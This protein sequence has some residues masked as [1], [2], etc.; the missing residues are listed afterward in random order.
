MSVYNGRRLRLEV[1]GASHVETIGMELSG[2]PAGIKIDFGALKKLLSRRAPGKNEYSSTRK[3]ADEPVFLSG[4]GPD[5]ATDGNVIKA[6]IYNRDADSSAYPD[7]NRIPRPSHADYAAV[8]KYGRDVDLRGGGIFSGRMTAVTCIAGELCRQYIKAFGV[9]IS[10]H[11]CQIGRIKDT[12]FSPVS[13]KPE[14]V[15]EDFPVLNKTQGE[16]MKEAVREARLEG[17]SLGGIVECKITGLSAG[18]G[19]H[20][21]DG[22]EERISSLVFSVPGV[23]AVEFGAGFEGAGMRGSEYNDGFYYSD[24]RVKTYTNN[25]GGILGGMTDGMPV[26]FRAAF[27]PTPSIAIEQN[28]VDLE[29]KENVRL[30][31]KGRHDPCIVPRAVPVMESVAAIAAADLILCEK[32]SS[33]LEELRRDIDRVD[34]ELV[35]LIDERN[36]IASEIGRYKREKGLP[37]FD[38][39]REDAVKRKVCSFTADN[40]ALVS[41]V[42][43]LLFEASRKRQ[44][45]G[46][47]TG[48]IGRKLAHSLSPEIHAMLSDGKY[49]LCELEP[50]ELERFVN[51]CQ[52]KGFNVTIPYKKDIIPFLDFVSEEAQSIGAVNTVVRTES[53]LAGY[54]TDVFGLEYLLSRSG[55]SVRNKKV[56]VTGSGGAS[57]AAVYTV[58]KL[59]AA[60]TVVISRSGENTYSDLPR[61]HDADVIINAT[62][63]GMYPANGESPLSLNGFSR[64]SGVVDLIYNPVKTRLLFEAEKLGIPCAGGLPMLVAQAVKSFELFSGSECTADIENIIRTVEKQQKNIVLTGMPG[65][66]K[67]AVGKLVAEKLGRPFY[68]TDEM[69]TQLAGED[70][71]SIFEKHGEEYFR[72][73]E[74]EVIKKTGAFRGSVIATGGGA[75]TNEDN[76]EPLKQN[77]TVVFIERNLEK[78]SVAG[79]PL[80]GSVGVG[81]LYAERKELYERFADIT[82]DNNGMPEKT[83]G[84]IIRK[85][86]LEK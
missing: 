28:S 29:K 19:E 39:E 3:E 58:K 23:K 81:R 33:G 8:M 13:E 48:L 65:C 62:P 30:T 77:S 25:C 61:H 47:D 43:G 75:V 73:L 49:T 1:T 11:I 85:L 40:S 76:Y 74:N 6:V 18:L 27:K 7:N 26:I 52:F 69:I 78:L 51:E 55:I 36:R 44:F 4:I 71:P 9:D 41:G 64:L 63:V 38:A 22:V 32:P 16:K 42:Y 20:I 50:E 17:N 60:E 68:D 84:M 24:G 80:S 67:T 57:A 72:R 54:N 53:G 66:G 35:A 10:A 31:V 15:C 70:I 45:A 86:R 12:P 59:G 83:A 14:D 2:L 37:V 82:A 34:R 5:G 21:F 46:L 79:R 56:L